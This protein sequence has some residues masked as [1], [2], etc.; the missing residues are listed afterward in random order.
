MP[1]YDPTWDSLRAH[2]TP[3]WMLDAKFGIY[4]HWGPYSVP[5]YGSEHY[6]RLMHHPGNDKDVYRNHREKW[7]APGT[8]DYH[9]FI[10]MFKAERFDPDEWGDAVASSGA[11]YAGIAAMHH[12]GFALWNSKVTRWNAVEMG[13]KRDCFGELFEAYRKRGLKTISTFHHIRTFDWFLTNTT[14]EELET[15]R[16]A[17]SAVLDPEYADF[18]WNHHTSEYGAFLDQWRARIREVIDE[19]QPDVVWFDGG[20]FREEGSENLVMGNLAYYLNRAEEWGKDVVVLNKYPASFVWNFPSDF[21]MLNYEA[22]RDRPAVVLRPWND[23]KMIG[24][25]WGYIDDMVYPTSTSLI[26]GLIDRVARG[27]GM[28]LSLS[29]KADGT[30]PD[31]E[32]RILADIGAWLEVNGEAIYGTRSWAIHAEGDSERLRDMSGPHTRWHFDDCNATDIRFTTKDGALYAIAMGWPE[33]GVLKITSLSGGGGLMAEQIEAVSVL[34][35]DAT[36]E[37]T[38]NQWDMEVVLPNERPCDHAVTVKI[39]FKGA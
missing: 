24:S 25:S 23:D 31:Q 21:G 19:Y 11:R 14:D 32:K 22:G 38:L 13:P 30:L 2:Q 18:Y 1:S 34:G 35:S 36:I 27:G 3:E 9:Q 29:P 39:V 7:G 4:A 16:A 8:F 17:G 12:D 6:G 5:A 15:M 28:L 37:W 33:D 26:H 10:P 20:K